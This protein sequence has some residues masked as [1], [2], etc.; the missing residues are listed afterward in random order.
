MNYIKYVIGFIANKMIAADCYYRI[1]NYKRKIHGK[2]YRLGGTVYCTFPEKIHI[3]EN[4]YINGGELCA[5]PNA[6]I[7]IGNNCLISYD[8]FARTD[9]HNYIKKEIL[10]QKQGVHEKDIV[11]SNDVWIGY[12]VQIMAGVT[13]AE[14]CVI[15]AGSVVTKDTEPYCLYAGVPAEKKKQ[16]H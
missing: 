2:N 3:G 12:G 15:A 16:R 11:I 8:F 6:D 9:V 13:I 10:I 5:S 7:Y 4:T 14:G 1:E